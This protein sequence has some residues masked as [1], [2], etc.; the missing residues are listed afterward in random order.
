MLQ[1]HGFEDGPEGLSAGERLEM[2][3]DCLD[4]GE[5][6]MLERFS[7]QEL[8]EAMLSRGQADEEVVRYIR[9]AQEV[10]LVFL[11]PGMCGSPEKDEEFMVE[12]LPCV[13][14][15]LAGDGTQP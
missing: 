14:P 1:A 9:I 11:H 15:E 8:Y 10:G 2:L 3:Q 7:P 12:V 5:L 4:R 6:G 13:F